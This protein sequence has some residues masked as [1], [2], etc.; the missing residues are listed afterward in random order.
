MLYCPYKR[1]TTAVAGS[2]RSLQPAQVIAAP[3][4]GR[5][6]TAWGYYTRLT[7]ILQAESGLFVILM[8]PCSASACT[9]FLFS[10]FTE[11]RKTHE[12]R[13]YPVSR[14]PGMFSVP[15]S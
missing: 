13:S 10:Q 12:S 1:K 9:V 7:L 2:W 6:R 4:N 11:R 14:V 8:T 15:G 5:I 3:H